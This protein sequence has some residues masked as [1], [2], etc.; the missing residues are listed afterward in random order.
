MTKQLAFCLLKSA[1]T[2]QPHTCARILYATG[3]LSKMHAA[4]LATKSQPTA[5]A[6]LFGT[7]THCSQRLTTRE[8]ASRRLKP[9][10]RPIRSG[11]NQAYDQALV[12]IRNDADAKNKE[13]EKIQTKLNSLEPSTSE[14]QDLRRKVQK[15]EISSKINLP[16]VRWNFKQGKEGTTRAASIFFNYTDHVCYSGFISTGISASC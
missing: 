4:R 16:E 13:L 3:L 6:R 8:P 5:S 15:L 2:K 12:L 7:S 9:W 14:Y 1:A 11:I 10:S